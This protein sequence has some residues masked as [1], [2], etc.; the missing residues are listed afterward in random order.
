MPIRS[1][2]Y[3]RYDRIYRVPRLINFRCGVWQTANGNL[4]VCSRICGLPKSVVAEA[5]LGHGV[6]VIF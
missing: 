4:N 3:D 2:R 6:R 1:H 5:P